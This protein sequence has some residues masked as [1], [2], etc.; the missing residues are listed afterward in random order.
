MRD[1][2]FGDD[3][4]HRAGGRDDSGAKGRPCS[5]DY[6][7][8][9]AYSAH[10]YL[11]DNAYEGCSRSLEFHSPAFVFGDGEPWHTR[12]ARPA[13]GP[14]A[15]PADLFVHRFCERYRF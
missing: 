4:T 8:Q 13:F 10:N 14:T 7:G 2:F 11:L 3:I 12:I 9:D 1:G 6:R 5:D 15:Q